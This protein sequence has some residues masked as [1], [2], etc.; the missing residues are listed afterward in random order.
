MGIFTRMARSGMVAP[1]GGSGGGMR[2]RLI[3]AVA[4]WVL[5]G[6]G[7]MAQQSPNPQGPAELP[8]E[9]FADVQYVDSTGCVFLRAG[10]NGKVMWIPRVTKDGR[11]L[12]GYA[13]SL[14]ASAPAAAQAVDAG[15]ALTAPAPAA[16]EVRPAAP[17]PED[18]QAKAAAARGPAPVRCAAEVPL[19][20]R[21]PLVSGGMAVMCL[22][23]QARMAS[24]TVVLRF[25]DAVPLAPAAGQVLV[26]PH[27][28]GVV[29]RVPVMSGGETLL[30]TAGTGSLAR[31]SVPKLRAGSQTLPATQ[32]RFVQVA[33][34]AEPANAER[35]RAWL[36]GLGLPVATG[37]L[38][39]RGQE[40]DVIFAG[41]FSTAGTAD[42]TLALVRD[43]GF[44]DAF[45]R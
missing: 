12:C 27:D 21:V 4:V 6:Q 23:D 37:R 43:A 34:F 41:P 44:E 15:I 24:Q 36:A 39:R 32:G 26:C 18:R 38:T 45:L 30:C 8:P 14:A 20:V 17:P 35:T 9:S 11:P 33:I 3:L 10:L 19:P 31:L 42:A 7:A 28:A 5:S 16:A 25:E 1:E 40:F 29:Q 2:V 22:T 13:P